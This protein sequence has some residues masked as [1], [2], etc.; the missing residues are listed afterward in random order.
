MNE[1]IPINMNCHYAYISCQR[2][3]IFNN[4]QQYC[5]TGILN[6]SGNKDFVTGHGSVCFTVLNI[7]Q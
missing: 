1:T 4:I 3:N 6:Y 7:V 2:N 5:F